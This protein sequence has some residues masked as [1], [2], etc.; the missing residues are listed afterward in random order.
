VDLRGEDDGTLLHMR[1]TYATITAYAPRYVARQLREAR[2]GVREQSEIASTAKAE[3]WFAGIQ[4]DTERQARQ[5]AI[6]REAYS[7]AAWFRGRET[8][9]AVADAV[10]RE[11]MEKTAPERRLAV[12]A[13]AEYRNRHPAEKLEP[14]RSAEPEPVTDEERDAFWPGGRDPERPGAEREEA[15]EPHWAK[16]LVERL[17]AQQAQKEVTGAAQQSA[18]GPEASTEDRDAVREEPAAEAGDTRGAEQVGREQPEPEH[19]TPEE[20]GW[21]KELAERNARAQEKLAEREAVQVPSEDPEAE[22]LGMA[23]PGLLDRER[24]PLLHPAELDMRPSAGVSAETSRQAGRQ[25]EADG[26]EAGG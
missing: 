13:D 22:G 12:A 14:L 16:D 18:A 26:P 19:D 24:D 4:G 7:K 8:E 11:Y 25:A 20:P 9:Y 17:A 1:G 3:A 2:L 10:H 23:W 15:P 6:A 21:V 5:E